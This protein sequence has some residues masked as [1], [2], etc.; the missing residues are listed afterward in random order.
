MIVI[1]IILH[2]KASQ[3]LCY[4]KNVES[5]YKKMVCLSV[6]CHINRVT[7]ESMCTFYFT[8]VDCSGTNLNPLLV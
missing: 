6:D 4:Q 3:T 1:Q 5:T 7:D 8:I 2:K